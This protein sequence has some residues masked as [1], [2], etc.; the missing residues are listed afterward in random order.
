VKRLYSEPRFA[1][2]YSLHDPGRPPEPSH[3]TVPEEAEEP[4]V[5]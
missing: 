4:C 1:T 5:V 2:P 3:W